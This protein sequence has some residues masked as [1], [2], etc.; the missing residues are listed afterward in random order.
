MEKILPTGTSLCR[1]ILEPKQEEVLGRKGVELQLLFVRTRSHLGGRQS[2]LELATVERVDDE[3]LAAAE[4][5]NICWLELH[6]KF[7]IAN[8]S[9]GT[10]YEIAFVLKLKDPTYGWEVLVNLRLT[11]PDGKKAK[12]I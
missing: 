3:S 5:L 1:C 2:L 12:K 9:P 7:E 10:I 8:L 11:L 4:L 6:G